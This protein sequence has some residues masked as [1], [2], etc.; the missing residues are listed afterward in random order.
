MPA[1]LQ[2]NIMNWQ[3]VSAQ[4]SLRLL[5]A[6]ALR[7]AKS[8]AMEVVQTVVMPHPLYIERAD[9]GRLTDVD[10]NVYLDLTGGFGPNVLGNRPAAVQRAGAEPVFLLE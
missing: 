7:A 6:L 8:L 3:N 10:G 1:Y 4:E 5:S 2:I 9:G